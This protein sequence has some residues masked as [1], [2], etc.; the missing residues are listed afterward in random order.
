MLFLC[1]VLEIRRR[2]SG[3]LLRQSL[4]TLGEHSLT[5]CPFVTT[6]VLDMAGHPLFGSHVRVPLADM[7]LHNPGVVTAI[8][9]CRR[10]KGG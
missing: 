8:I 9:E 6:D 4:I 10:R 3:I 5:S 2:A 7:G 1:V